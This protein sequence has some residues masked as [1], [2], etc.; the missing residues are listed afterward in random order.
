VRIAIINWSLRRIGGVENYLTSLIPALVSK[1]QDVSLLTEIDEPADRKRISQTDGIPV[2]CTI[3]GGIDRAIASLAGWKPDVVYVQSEIEPELERQL[4][5]VA[6][7]VYFAH[8]YSGA[9]ISGSKLRRLPSMTACER[10][11]GWRC[12]L[13][14]YPRRCGGLNPITMWT[15]YARA[16]RRAARLHRYV[17]IVTASE[18]MKREYVRQGFDPDRVHVNWLPIAI[19]HQPSATQHDSSPRTNRLTA[20]GSEFRLLFVG[21]MERVKGGQ[22][23]VDAL[24]Q[25]SAMLA[26]PIWLN[27]IG[28]GRERESWTRRA[29]SVQ[30][31]NPGVHVRFGG[32]LEGA[33][34]AES[35]RQADLLVMPSL[36]PEPFGMVG[37]E[38]GRYAL[39]A[40]AFDV[41]GISDWLIDGVNG[42]FAPANPATPSALAGAV[43]RASS[44]RSHYLDL[45]EGARRTVVRFSLDSHVASLIELFSEFATGKAPRGSVSHQS[46]NFAREHV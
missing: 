19:Y 3:D 43:V 14:Y 39:P 32:W 40:V 18:H 15:D 9:C 27:F 34:L 29:Q 11:L 13:H 46:L 42:H 22:I 2:W 35:F 1:G 33:A 17:A 31:R 4:M 10:T 25:I 30:S 45:C 5:E 37:P 28:D 38:A 7:S 24:P 41:G 21:R 6:P 26:K 36:W 12:L 20:W 16:T 44:D 8:N 23:L